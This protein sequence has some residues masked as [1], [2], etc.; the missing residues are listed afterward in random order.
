M[1]HEESK[2]HCGVT[3]PSAQAGGA[4]EFYL[5]RYRQTICSGDCDLD[6]AFAFAEAYADQKVA[7]LRQER[8]D[9]KRDATYHKALSDKAVEAH[10]SEREAR[11]RAEGALREAMTNLAT[12]I[13][14][15]PV[16][17]LTSTS[18]VR[19]EVERALA[20]LKSSQETKDSGTA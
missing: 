20:A 9:W 8:D 12:M 5:N 6:G 15:L 11:E 10:K 16:G 7:Q 14:S 4:R 18:M 2:P 17:G 13:A 19:Y 1:N 3:K